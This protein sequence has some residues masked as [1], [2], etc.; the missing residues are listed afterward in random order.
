MEAVG[1]NPESFNFR[2]GDVS[3]G[4]DPKVIGRTTL[5]IVRSAPRGSAVRSPSLG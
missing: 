3:R 4:H 5:V 1:A 2:R